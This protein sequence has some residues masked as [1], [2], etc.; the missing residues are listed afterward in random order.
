MGIQLILVLW[1]LG[2]AH[3]YYYYSQ[4]E[5]KVLWRVQFLHKGIDL[6]GC[7]LRS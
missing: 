2:K 6:A 1:E 4:K 3:R 5:L 7:V